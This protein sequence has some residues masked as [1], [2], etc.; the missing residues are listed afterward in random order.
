MMCPRCP[1]CEASHA[2]RQQRQPN[3]EDMTNRERAKA[4][5]LEQC[6]SEA[7]G[8]RFGTENVDDGSADT[9]TGKPCDCLD[10]LTKLLDEAEQRGR[11]WREKYRP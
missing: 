11:F 9:E 6:I 3:G 4:W 1:A 8:T 5:M 2:R 10:T 7:T